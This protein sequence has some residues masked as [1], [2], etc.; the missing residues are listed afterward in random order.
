MC[1]VRQDCHSPKVKAKAKA[2]KDTVDIWVIRCT[3]S[4]ARNM[5]AAQ[6]A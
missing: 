6:E 4:R 2:N 3:V 1:Q 5:V